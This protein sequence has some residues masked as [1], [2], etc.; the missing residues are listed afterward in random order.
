MMFEPAYPFLK[1]SRSGFTFI[2]LI[3][4]IVIVGIILAVI[5]PRAW[6]ARVEARYGLVRQAATE[7]GSWGMTWAERNLE[8]QPLSDTSS[9]P[10]TCVLS[11]YVDTLRGFTGEQTNFSNWAGSPKTTTIRS[12]NRGIASGTP[13]TYTVA[14]IMPQDKQ[15]RNPFNGASYLIEAND[16]SPLQ[17]GQL[18]LA[19]QLDTDGFENYYLVYYGTDS[20]GDLEWHAGMGSGDW[21]NNI[22]LENLRNGVFVAR[23]RF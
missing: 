16:G 2:E 11:N 12:C 10:V 15:P 4:V 3:L 5:V 21:D 13:I 8:S 7:M 18:Y 9:N 22:P 1:K 14:D 20:S 6:R 19:G 23:L 17:T